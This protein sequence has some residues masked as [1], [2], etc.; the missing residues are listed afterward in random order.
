MTTMI[1]FFGLI[2]A[3]HPGLNSIGRL[4]VIGLL[5]CFVAAVIVLPAVLEILDRIKRKRGAVRVGSARP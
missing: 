1:G 2:M 4:A 3:R 5:T